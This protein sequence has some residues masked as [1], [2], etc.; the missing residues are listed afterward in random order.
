MTSF[1]IQDKEQFKTIQARFQERS[2]KKLAT[3]V[4]HVFY[5]IVRGRDMKHGFTPLTNENKLKNSYNNQPWANF[6]YA[7]CQVGWQSRP[8][9][10]SGGKL[11]LSS[12]RQH[13]DFD[14]LFTVEQWKAIEEVANG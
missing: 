9:Y 3:A 2:R 7:R 12:I 10:T 1:I 14:N 4:D 13:Y 5:N 11:V 6:T 8:P